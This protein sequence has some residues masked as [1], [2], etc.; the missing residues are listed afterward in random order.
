MKTRTVIAK[1]LKIG[2]IVLDLLE[3]PN[4]QRHSKV[5]KIE[6]GLVG[7]EIIKDYFSAFEGQLMWYDLR[8]SAATF[9][10]IENIDYN[11]IWENIIHE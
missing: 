6:K 4:R 3:F 2:Q 8:N 10:V 11:K 5:V 9:D 1:D 7:L